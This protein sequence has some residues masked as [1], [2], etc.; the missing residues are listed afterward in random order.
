MYTSCSLHITHFRPYIPF[1]YPTDPTT[2]LYDDLNGFYR[3][4]PK[5]QQVIY[6]HNFCTIALQETHLRL[7]GSVKLFNYS[8]FRHEKDITSHV[9][10]GVVILVSKSYKA[11]CLLRTTDRQNI[12]ISSSYLTFQK[13]V[14]QYV[15]STYQLIKS[16]QS[17]R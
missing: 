9:N 17:K 10:G 5:L 4:L 2:D 12:T 13:E 11:T 8:I 15:Q 1:Q 6:T 7:K 14:S 3:Y 16:S